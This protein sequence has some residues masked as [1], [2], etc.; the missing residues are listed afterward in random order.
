MV[1]YILVYQQVE[2]YFLSPHLTRRTMSLHPAAA[3]AAALIGGAL[4][5]VVMAFLALPAAGV[6]QASM[7]EYGKRYEV[8]DT[9]L[10]E[11][12]APHEPK[13][14]AG[15][16]RFRRGAGTPPRPDS[17]RS[18]ADQAAR[19]DRQGNRASAAFA[20]F[21]NAL[22]AGASWPITMLEMPNAM[23]DFST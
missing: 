20:S 23:V 6:I 16:R 21:M 7:S 14:K 22:L 17:A 19:S 4:G 5:G 18:L 8:V 10:T 1:G 13:P 9:A 11:D 12:V 3:F 2:N 15:R